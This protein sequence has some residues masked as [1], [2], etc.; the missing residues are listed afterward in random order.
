MHSTEQQGRLF[1]KDSHFAAY[2]WFSSMLENCESAPAHS[3]KRQFPSKQRENMLLILYH[4]K[5]E[6]D[7]RSTV[8]VPKS[9]RYKRKVTQ[10]ITYLKPDTLVPLCV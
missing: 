8:S 10:Y 4:S 9:G 5:V 1:L 6:S 2:C 7:S 3:E